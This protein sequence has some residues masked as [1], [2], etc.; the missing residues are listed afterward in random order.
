MS[1]KLLFKAFAL[2]VAL[3]S[4][5][6]AKAYDFVE[7]GFYL[8][9]TGTNTVE[10]TYNNS[11]PDYNS[12]T[13]YV[14]I[15]A[16]ITHNGTTYT[17]T[18]IGNAAFR[19]C[20][21]LTGVSIPN[22]V[23][24][25]GNFAFYD[26]PGLTN[27]SIPYG[28]THL[29]W[30]AFARTGLTSIYIPGSV[31]YI[32]SEMFYYCT[33]LR[34]VIL[35]ETIT[36]FDLMRTFQGCTSLSRIVI[37]N[38]VAA[39]QADAFK[40][41]TS[42]LEVT[43][44]RTTATISSGAFSGCTALQTVSCFA[45]TP[46]TLNN[47]NVFPSEAYSNATLNVPSAAQSAYQAAN[48]WK[49]FNNINGVN[50]DFVLNNLKYAITSNTTVKCLGTTQ[51][52]P[53]GPWII[54]G[55]AL[56]YD[57]TEIGND[58]FSNCDGITSIDIGPKVQSIGTW[59]FYGCT[60][61]TSVTIPNSVTYV[62]GMAFF[63]C[64]SLESIVIGENCRFNNSYS[65]ALNIFKG[66]SSLTSITCLSEEP[67][68]FH[69]PMFDDA[70]YANAV[71]WV[72]GGSEAAYQATDFWYKFSQIKG[73][74]T[75]DEALNV[76]GGDLHFYSSGQYPWT[77]MVTDDYEPYAQSGNAGVSS[78]TSTLT[79]TVYAVDGNILEFDFKA[80]GE[81]SSTFWDRC[82]FSIN[83]VEQIA[84]G[85]YQNENWETYSVYL[86]AGI[87]T[88][89]WSYS[90]DN[91][92]NPTGDFFAIKDVKMIV[93]E[94]KR[95]DVN[96]D[97]NVDISDAT[98]LINYLLSGNSSG[99]NLDAANVNNDSGVDITDATALINY[100]LYGAW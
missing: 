11:N 35:P 99:L 66:C 82:S 60:G 34:N 73:T 93:P 4:A 20:D 53:I 21:G 97:G 85:A 29:G 62:G 90:K 9:I 2:A 67:W 5:L 71:V 1:R 30:D 95:G 77:V 38:G 59:A 79:A 56:G 51:N 27:I 86:P 75:L 87:C 7:P 26:C 3:A 84:Y 47:N 50:Y 6:G 10:I 57:V 72:P 43:I 23:T 92:V 44:P 8:N 74:Y 41:C 24:R 89:E 76:E 81:G 45:T 28:V 17:V 52:S 83:G 100:L 37:P 12:Y 68:E 98:A 36:N 49:L 69:E 70:T 19:N 54:P 64:S 78:S 58:A 33:S 80:W 42:L 18:A 40:G 94:T 46:P 96:N 91:S 61:L 22:T 14:S 32:G 39:I 65:W 88:L 48:G 25:I 63:N 31:T 55:T 13:G 16:S 15:P